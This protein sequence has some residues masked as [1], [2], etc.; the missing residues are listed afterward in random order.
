MRRR[1]DPLIVFGVPISGAGMALPNWGRV[2]YVDGTDGNEGAPAIDPESPEKY[3]ANVFTKS[4]FKSND[5][6]CVRG[7]I[8]EQVLAPLGIFGVKIL[9]A[10]GGA[11]RHG[12]NN[13]VAISGNGA[14]WKEE[15]TAANA[16]LLELREQGWEV[17]NVLLV[18]ESG[19]GAVKLHREETATYPDA[20]HFVMEDCR[21][22]SSGQVGLGIDD[23][24]ASY[25]IR[26]RRNVFENLEFAYKASGVGIAAPSRHQ[27]VENDF[28]T[29]K[30]DIYGNFAGS[31]FKGNRFHTLYDGTTHPNT[32]N[33]AATADA[34]VATEKNY[35]IENY[36][37][38]AAADVT[39]DK[40]YK[41]ATGDVWRNYVA[42][43]A[44]Q[45]ITVPS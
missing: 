38:D 18:P 36:F 42:N 20:S 39:V 30:N 43:T 31:V 10:A 29:N 16:P 19:Y 4:T 11:P 35:V 41:P 24:G 26:V 33:L 8:A 15:A 9:G 32:I 34:G 12:T 28:I 14:H 13:G 44:A 25:N 21:V 6:I 22:I 23:S 40:G 2:F 27:F 7:V 37:A 3:I 17:H 1:L 45:I 5:I